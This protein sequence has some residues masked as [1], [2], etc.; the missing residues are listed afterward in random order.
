M[1]GKPCEMCQSPTTPCPV[2][3]VK[4]HKFNNP[5][6]YHMLCN[7][8][9]G[10]HEDAGHIDERPKFEMP[11]RV[12]R[13]VKTFAELLHASHLK[14]NWRFFPSSRFRWCATEVRRDDAVAGMLGAPRFYKTQQLAEV[15][16]KAAFSMYVVA[17]VK[18]FV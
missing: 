6:G 14:E 8:C 11:T 17:K 4:E 13:K 5:E 18:G 3:S 1:T 9:G 10:R 12:K 16:A 15:Y 7:D 2:H